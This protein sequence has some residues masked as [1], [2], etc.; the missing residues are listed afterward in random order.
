M[1]TLRFY[2]M[3]EPGIYKLRRKHESST[4]GKSRYGHGRG[5]DRKKLVARPIVLLRVFS[6]RCRSAYLRD[7]VDETDWIVI[8]PHR[9]RSGHCI[10]QLLR[11]NGDR[12]LAWCKVFFTHVPTEGLR[13]CRSC[14][15]CLGIRD[16][17]DSA[18]VRIIHNR[19]MVQSFIF[20]FTNSD[21]CRF[22]FSLVVARD[23]CTWRNAADDGQLLVGERSGPVIELSQFVTNHTCLR[24]EHCRGVTRRIGSYFFHAG[25]GWRSHQQLCRRRFVCSLCFGCLEFGKWKQTRGTSRGFRTRMPVDT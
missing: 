23:D 24:T 17:G 25:C 11:R 20:R 14:C 10:G 16:S 18:T 6:F 22:Q 19:T 7:F 12:V 2:L 8:R 5:F 1:A 4:T 13:Y 15:C 9:T 21:A 3:L